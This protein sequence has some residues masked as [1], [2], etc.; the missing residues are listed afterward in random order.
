MPKAFITG[1]AGFLGRALTEWL[2]S[3]DI[4]VTIYSRDEAKHAKA[5]SQFP[6]ARFIIGDIQNRDLLEASIMGHDY[7]IHAAAMKYVPQAETNVNAAIR[8]NVDG[9]RMVFNAA[10]RARVSRVVSISTDK[11]CSPVNVYGYTKKLMERMSQEFDTYGPTDF[12]CVRYGNVIASTGS[13]IPIF[14]EQAR[15]RELKVTDPN[16]T[17]FWLTIENAVQLVRHSLNEQTP[18]TILIER[19][20]ATDMLTVAR[21]AA[22]VE[23]GEDYTVDSIKTTTTGH[24]FGEKT[25]EELVGMEERFHTR[26]WGTS[27]YMEIDPIWEP[28]LKDTV[29]SNAPYYTSNT[30]DHWINPI[31]MAKMIAASDEPQLPF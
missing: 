18:G 23:L 7:V 9:S 16:M 11:A 12:V 26:R 29:D 2:M 3:E 4:D 20:A 21:A 6:E 27:P 13:V 25:H 24:R 22:M 8:V 31:Q 10:L 17:R 14:R 15:T 1:G 28:P 19:L 30:P 5:R